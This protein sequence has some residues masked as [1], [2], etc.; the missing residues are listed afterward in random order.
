MR[1]YRYVAYT[2]GGTRR[3]GVV[4]ADDASDAG[5]RLTAQGLLP[6]EVAAEAPGR[7]VFTERAL[8]RDRLAVLTRQLAVLVGAG[9]T[10]EQALG[11]VQGA[12][13][14]RRV[15]RLVARAQAQLLDGAPLS[16]AL[17]GAGPPAWY[18]A[19]LAAGERSGEV[20]LTLGTLADHLEGATDERGALTSA[21]VYPAFVVAVALAVCGVL[22]TTV[23]PE[24]AG[25]FQAQGRPL[26]PLTAALMALTDGVRAHW[27]WLAAGALGVTALLV[28]AARIPA[29]RDRRDRLTLMVPLVGRL[30]RQAQ[31]AAWLRV[32]ALAVTA[33]LP[34]VEALGFAAGVLDIAVYRAQ[35][36]GAA[37][38]M[39]RGERLG[40]ALADL[41]FLHPV[42]RQL[43]EAGAAGARLAPM[44]DRAATLAETWARTDRKRLTALLEP[45]AM[46]VVG[47]VVLTVV[48]AVLLPVF[49]LQGMVE[50]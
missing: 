39:V 41:S 42:S 26:P 30:R 46:I 1:P 6:A 8:G 15:E 16:V 49:D 19:A 40:R 45:L 36:E 3:R 11:A 7:G 9:L 23:A 31:A 34:L 18:L 27:P 29:W 24:I 50:I 20:A 44:A 14:D 12:A 22:M 48:M 10:V 13:Q 17:A 43:I 25:L 38:A 33:R 37:A 2:S 35:A 21:L 32:L 4:L 5:A 47:L 28:A